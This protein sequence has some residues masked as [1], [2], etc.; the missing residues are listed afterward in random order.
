MPTTAELFR[1]HHLALYRY[2]RRLT[3]SVETAEELAQE[4]FL[5]VARSIGRFSTRGQDRAWVFRIASNLVRNRRRDAARRPAAVSFDAVDGS[6]VATGS[7]DPGPRIELSRALQALAR[8]DR[9]VFL[10]REVAGLGYAEIAA[11]TGLTRD[12][13]RNRIHRARMSLRSTLLA[14]P[15]ENPR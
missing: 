7:G 14:G 1:D 4:T 2:L 8:E 11:V 15:E 12:A 6:T 5:R 13:V 9:E 10:L 3:G